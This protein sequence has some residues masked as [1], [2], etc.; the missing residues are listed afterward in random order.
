MLFNSTMDKYG[1][2][3]AKLLAIR[4][5]AFNGSNAALAR[6]IGKSDSYVSRMMYTEDKKGHKRIGDDSITAL[7]EAFS[8]SRGTFD[9]L[10]LE[11]LLQAVSEATARGSSAQNG[12]TVNP[13]ITSQKGPVIS[14]QETGK[15]STLS[16]DVDAAALTSPQRLRA[17]LGITGIAP[18]ELASVAKTGVDTAS[19]WLSGHGPEISL[20]QAVAI[21]NTYGVNVVWLT[22]G[23]G[24]P[25][26]AVRYNDKFDPIPITVW[27]SIPV[28]GMAQLGDNGHWADLEYPVGVG[29][30]YVDFPTRDPHAYALKC[31]GD[32][33][34]P[35]IQAGEFVVIEPSHPYEP[36]DDVL[37]KSM[38]GRVMIKRF[39]YKRGGRTHVI[40]VNTAH[41]PMAFADAEIEKIHFV[42]AICRP[43]SWRP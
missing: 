34:L 1:D 40:S 23:K 39:L 5:R 3:R 8:L 24:K 20:E 32:S 10:A 7:E 38:D 9:F 29:E 4:D 16:S 19:Q 15:S 33:M 30:G 37:L 11:Q 2:R 17:S 28:V 26:V 6:K 14:S 42:R 31:E 27:K 41:A 12:K 21:Q 35:R 13:A 43:S 18:A 25:G 22:K 36:G